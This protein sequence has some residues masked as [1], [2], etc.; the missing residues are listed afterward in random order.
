MLENCKLP[1][2]KKL[3]CYPNYILKKNLFCSLQGWGR[4]Q[5]YYLLHLVTFFLINSDFFVGFD[6]EKCLFGCS[7]KIR[8][9]YYNRKDQKMNVLQ[10]SRNSW[11][12][13]I[14][15]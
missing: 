3:H 12:K 10:N 13:S 11:S 8:C 1:F 5:E 15:Q 4:K 6:S 2:N 7:M 14:G 9:F